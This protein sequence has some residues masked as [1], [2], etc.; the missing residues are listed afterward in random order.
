MLSRLKVSLFLVLAHF[1]LMGTPLTAQTKSPCKPGDRSSKDC[2]T[3]DGACGKATLERLRFNDAKCQAVQMNVDFMKGADAKC[4]SVKIDPIV[5]DCTCK[6][7]QG[8][9]VPKRDVTVEQQVRLN[10]HAECEVSDWDPKVRTKIGRKKC[11][12]DSDQA[13]VNE[14]KSKCEVE[15]AALTCRKIGY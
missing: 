1:S 8:C 6:C 2:T 3:P 7:P 12:L 15:C 4:T 13:G 5:I 14:F 10:G 11:S 9:M